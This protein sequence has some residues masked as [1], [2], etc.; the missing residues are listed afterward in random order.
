MS[1]NLKIFVILLTVIAVL[2]LYLIL[3]SR[4]LDGDRAGNDDQLKEIKAK[5][6]NDYK[7]GLNEVLAEYWRLSSDEDISLEESGYL[8]NRLLELKV[9]A[10]L[11][12]FHFGLVMAF[13]KLESGSEK[14]R[15]ESKQ[16]IEQAMADYEW[17]D[18]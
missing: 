2:S 15:A 16:I 6:V 4:P 14:E 1:R 18:E 10:D 12:G 13:D 8:K 7:G 3:T 5:L 17:L 9:P 11:K